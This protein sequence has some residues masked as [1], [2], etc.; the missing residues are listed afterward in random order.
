MNPC[1]HKSEM[2]MI[3]TDTHIE[4]IVNRSIDPYRQK[5]SICWQMEQKKMKLFTIQLQYVLNTKYGN[6]KTKDPCK[7]TP[8]LLE[9]FFNPFEEEFHNFFLQNLTFCHKGIYL[10]RNLNQF[11]IKNHEKVH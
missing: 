3:F 6:L 10:F 11:S 7:M 1:I 8:I 4:K 2:T 9:Y 5:P